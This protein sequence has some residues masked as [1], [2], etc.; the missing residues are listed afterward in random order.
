MTGNQP[1]SGNGSSVK[2]PAAKKER[3]RSGLE[4]LLEQ[5]RSGAA[6][7]SAG[8]SSWPGT[9]SAEQ[10]A[11]QVLTSLGMAVQEARAML[12]YHQPAG[13]A[14]SSVSAAQARHV[15]GWLTAVGVPVGQ[16][17]PVLRAH[18]AALAAQPHRDWLP[19]VCTSRVLMARPAAAV[20]TR[21]SSSGHPLTLQ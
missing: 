1:S 6:A 10:T 21:C 15:C 9:D 8:S 3:R 14:G 18:P 16:L 11:T 7:G 12:D 19:K 20:V 2:G 4:L 5:S 13:E 17:A